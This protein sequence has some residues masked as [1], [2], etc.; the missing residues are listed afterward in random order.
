MKHRNKNKM[1]AGIFA[2][3]FVM[4]T[5]A[6]GMPAFASE[7]SDA[8]LTAAEAAAVEDTIAPIAEDTFVETP[9][10]PTESYVAPTEAKEDKIVIAGNF[11]MPDQIYQGEDVDVIGAVYSAV[12]ALKSVTVGVY[13]TTGGFVTGATAEPNTDF[14]D[15]SRLDELVEFNKLAVGT[16]NFVVT[17]T[18]ASNSN[19]TLMVKQFEVKEKSV[20]PVTDNIGIYG[21]SVIPA[22]IVS[23]T[24]VSV[25][26]I[27]T[28]EVS[29]LQSVTV[30]VY[31]DKMVRVTSA[32][33]R[34]DALSYDL[35]RLDSQMSFASLAAGTYTYRVIAT[36][37]TNA[38]YV[39]QESSFEVTAGTTPILVN[40]TLSITNPTQVPDTLPIGSSVDVKG[41]VTSASSNITFLTC[42]VYDMSGQ[43]VTG[44]HL[45]VN[46]K[47][48]DL[49]RLDAFVLF[50]TL[51]AGDYAFAVI[52]SNAANSNYALVNK[53]FTVTAG[54][55]TV[56]P[57]AYDMITIDG[58]TPIPDAINKGVPVSIRG[59]VNSATS[60]LNKITV[61]ITDASNG[62]FLSG[63]TVAIDRKNY[64]IS[65]LDQYVMFNKLPDGEYQF[66]VLASNASCSE[67]PVY[68]K[69]FT[70]G[71]GTVAP[72]QGDPASDTM[73]VNDMFQ[74]PDVIVPGQTVSV[75]GTAFSK[76]TNFTSLTVGVYASNGTFATGKTI[77]PRTP[78]YD[79]R[80]LDRYVTFNSLPEGEYTFAVIASNGSRKDQA[81]YTKKFKVAA[82]S[83]SPVYSADGITVNGLF[84]IP[85]SIKPGTAIN[86]TGTVTSAQSNL[87]SITVGVYNLN[88]QLVT[89]KTLPVNTKTFDLKT[90]DS[91][92]EFNKLAADNDYSFRIYATNA[93]KSN[94]QLISQRFVVSASSTPYSTATD[95]ITL[96]NMSTIP[97]QIKLGQAVSISGTVTSATSDMTALTVGV[98]NNYGQFVTGKTIN[99]RSKTY[100]LKNLDYAVEFNNLNLGTYTYA[101]IASNGSNTNYTVLSK[102][103]SVVNA[104]G[105][106]TPTD[107]G[108][109]AAPY[110]VG[111]TAVPS[112]LAV[113]QTLSVKGTVYSSSAMSS[114]TVGVYDTTGVFRTGRTIAPGA[115]VYDVSALD[116]YVEF[117]KLP[118]G[119]YVYAV[120]V[121]NATKK[122][123]AVVN[124]SFTI[125]SGSTTPIGS[126][127]L[128]VY[129]SNSVPATLT[130]GR[131]LSVFGT[132]TS[133]SS[134]MTSLTCG[135]YDSNGRFVTG[136]T[137]NPNARSYDL[138][139]LDAYVS[140]NTLPVGNYTYAVIASNASHSNYPLVKTK[141]S[142]TGAVDTVASD[143]FTLQGGTSIP[144]LISQGRGVLV[145]GIL[146]SAYSPI[147]SV[148]VGVY[149][150][151][152]VM[153]TGASAS[154][155][156]YSYN[157]NVL[158][159]AILFDKLTSGTYYYRVTASNGSQKNYTVVNKYFVV[160]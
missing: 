15:I 20:A 37:S 127:A 7:V 8:I 150:A 59:I 99:P 9:P 109:S 22:S 155:N 143:A 82:S 135:V 52:A 61:S 29:L 126:D 57:P 66:N 46:A 111:G 139:K 100:S 10:A 83:A 63:K 47:T 129:G 120:I 110:I 156:T 31:N 13:S 16:Y 158:D 145:T 93:T 64:Y 130:Q 146:S 78:L 98:Y 159:S 77:N 142:V 23:G 112:S 53:K 14:Y 123:Y 67:Y 137:I 116:S 17:A 108:T 56:T 75:Y 90:V 42:A 140:F 79:L 118:A 1:L 18:N 97:D 141:F 2:V 121:T 160:Q 113:G 80:N 104:G 134:N 122:D 89:G 84:T 5:G 26:G 3:L 74:M 119:S 39:V 157:L 44:R 133:G 65:N 72:Q 32:S 62:A 153:V 125:G 103:F 70:V 55:K 131:P 19:V 6:V 128:T 45:A 91:A 76:A 147:S 43:I 24:P 95:A 51:P 107:S 58:M 54:S 102:K 71:T 33:A 92:I 87:T 4:Q 106:S 149:N 27:V 60:N 136:R 88:N 34:P 30:A 154:P 138:K 94:V 152:G 117:N 49:S 124:K 81:L 144:S 11:T 36:N 12:S 41:V 68:T 86:V 35:S 28:S 21:A 73:L 69:K 85:S 48:Y 101:V 38:S 151:S 132:V 148:T 105:S 96:S 50:D 25:R 40:D 115:A 114:L